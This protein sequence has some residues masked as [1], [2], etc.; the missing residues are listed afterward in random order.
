[1]NTKKTVLSILLVIAILVSPVLPYRQTTVRAEKMQTFTIESESLYKE[2]RDRIKLEKNASMD[3]DDANKTIQLDLEKVT[4]ISLLLSDKDKK[5]GQYKEILSTLLRDCTNLQILKLKNCDIREGDLSVLDRRES[6]TSLMLHGSQIE[7]VPAI[8]LPNL[9][10]FCLT[11]NDLSADGACENINKDH[12]PALTE[13][14]LGNCKIADIDFIQNVGDLRVLSL[15]QNRLTDEDIT[16][17][18]GMKNLSDLE[19]LDLGM[20]VH[21]VLGGLYSFAPDTSSNKFTDPENLAS[22][23]TR[24][25]KVKNLDLSGLGITSLLPFAGMNEGISVNFAYNKIL[26]FAGLERNPGIK[27]ELH[28]QTISL[29]WDGVEEEIELPE[30]IRRVLDPDDVL[31][32]PAD[33]QLKC[34][35]CRLSED[36]KKIIILSKKSTAFVTVNAGKLDGS[37]IKFI[38]KVTP[39][40]KIP[41][42]LTADEGDTLADISLPDGFAWKDPSC[43]VGAAG[44]KTFQ[45]VYT[46]E[47]TDKYLIVDNIDISVTVRKAVVPTPKPTP[48]QTP[49]PSGTP[50]PTGTPVP[51]PTQTPKPDESRLTGNQI[52]KR[53]DLSLLLATGKQKGSRGIR[54]TWR[55]KNGC[56]GYEV[57]WSYCD[58]KQNYK[59]LKTVRNNGKR[60]YV[61]KKLKKNRA[62]KYY[63]ATY[64]MKGG[65]KYYQSK[66]PSIH[67]AMKK[68]KHTNAKRIKVNK[69]KVALKVNKKFQIKA[70]A[71]L[72]NRKK[73]L[74]SHDKKFRYYVDNREVAAVSNKGKI[75]AKKKGTCTVFVITNNGVAKQIRV[76]VK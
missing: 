23:L 43:S 59:K 57:Y 42:G 39:L 72:E 14:W 30:L 22:I 10:M 5:D 53:K 44:T 48:T 71:V 6:M 51:A 50:A 3:K 11:K 37:K 68:E 65:R 21:S 54:L 40:Y 13:L 1:M 27:I 16:K 74:L 76:T 29:P 35:D 46:P 64:T 41:E 7:K 9:Q 33:V 70:K 36:G 45:A 24:F 69:T 4:E 15:S 58:G 19:Q 31:Y 52:E 66:S 73:K 49:K 61:H 12:F 32:S 75:T 20:R 26:D 55:K 18:F 25:P 17:L 38:Q 56:A 34:T 28:D 67:V 62:Y 47:D 2:L 60:E 8:T 63:I